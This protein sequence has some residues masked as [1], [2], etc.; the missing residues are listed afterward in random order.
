MS[1][2]TAP[3]TNKKQREE[4]KNEAAK[5]RESGKLEKALNMFEEV[6][7][8][9]KANE[10]TKGEVDV[11]GH[12]RICYTRL[13]DE[14]DEPTKAT[15]LRMSA[16]EISEEALEIAENSNAF[17]KGGVA[18]Q[19]IHFASAMMDIARNASQGEK[20]KQLERG[21]KIIDEAIA[22]L[23][24]SEAHKAWPTNTKG[25][26]LAELGRENEALQV[27]ID[28]EK[29][30][31]A[32]YHDEVAN[33]DQAKMKMNVWWSGLLI[34]RAG[35]YIKQDKTLLAKHAL[36][37]VLQISKEEKA[38]GERAKEAQRMLDRM[39]DNINKSDTNANSKTNSKKLYFL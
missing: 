30:I 39:S 33:G 14:A 12:I 7:A 28:G 2:K 15:E 8:W 23:P 1:E 25:K 19:K 22:N 5:V 20:T 9:D 11:M 35:I 34:T 31:S 36:A 29:F 13:A 37:T 3:I 17:D 26:I 18:I 24:G 10:N 16:I 32:G 27:L 38:L 4:I 21:L 6:R